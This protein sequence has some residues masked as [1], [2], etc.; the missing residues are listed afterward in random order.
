MKESRNFELAHLEEEEEE[1]EIKKER[2]NNILAV[3]QLSGLVF[4]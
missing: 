2:K 4:S 3:W 1:E